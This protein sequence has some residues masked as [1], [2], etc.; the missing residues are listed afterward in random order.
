MLLILGTKIAYRQTS[1]REAWRGKSEEEKVNILH[2]DDIIKRN[3]TSVARQV[4]Q[5]K[6]HG[7]GLSTV[8]IWGFYQSTWRYG[9][10]QSMP[11]IQPSMTA[12]KSWQ[13]PWCLASRRWRIHYAIPC[14]N[15]QLRRR[16]LYLSKIPLTILHTGPL[17]HFHIIRIT[18][19]TFLRYISLTM[20]DLCHLRHVVEL[21]YRHHH[22]LFALKTILTLINWWNISISWQEDILA[23]PNSLGSVC[24]HWRVKRSCSQR[25]TTSLTSCGG[26]GR[27]RMD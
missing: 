10:C 18:I 14:L 17:F 19:H 27:S 16:Q 9:V 25:F 23:R 21:S 12:Q 4:V 13:R 26:N 20:N 7:A 24:W 15:L 6:T 5:I 1:K 2:I 22:H 8:Y 3:V 11:A